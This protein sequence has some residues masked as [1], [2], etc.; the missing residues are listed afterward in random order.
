MTSSESE[1]DSEEDCHWSWD[2]PQQGK[3][4][5]GK[6]IGVMTYR[7]MYETVIQWHTKEAGEHLCVHCRLPYNKSGSDK[8]ACPQYVT[9]YCCHSRDH[10]DQAG[11]KS[12]IN[13]GAARA[14]RT[15]EK[16]RMKYTDCGFKCTV[17]R[18]CNEGDGCAP[19]PPAGTKA[20][21]GHQLHMT[22]TNKFMWYFDSVSRQ[23]QFN[24]KGPRT[25]NQT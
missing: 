7:E 25:D 14:K 8:T 1:W 6:N 24:Q 21:S 20:L 11:R 17:R 4:A 12:P 15:E 3:F 19:A 22:N 16:L 2:V 13:A 5:H 9:F 23:N 10:G 18:I